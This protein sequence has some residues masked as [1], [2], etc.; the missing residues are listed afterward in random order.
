MTGVECKRHFKLMI[1]PKVK[2]KFKIAYIEVD[3]HINVYYVTILQK[4]IKTGG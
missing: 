2:K 4:S 1:Q 3:S